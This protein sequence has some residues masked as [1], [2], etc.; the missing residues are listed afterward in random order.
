MALAQDGLGLLLL[1]PWLD[2]LLKLLLEIALRLLLEAGL[3]AW[4]LAGR[5]RLE[6]D[7]RV[8]LDAAWLERR[9]LEELSRLDELALLGRLKLELVE[10]DGGVALD[11]GGT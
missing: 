8:E 3:L 11:A 10:L 7:G 2:R 9:L 4:L 6:E 5:A 1:L